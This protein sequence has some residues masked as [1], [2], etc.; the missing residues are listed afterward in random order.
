MEQRFS[1]YQARLKKAARELQ[2]VIAEKTFKDEIELVCTE[3]DQAEFRVAVIG[4]VNDG[5]T[6]FLNGMLRRPNLLPMK[7]I[8]WTA[9]VTKLQFGHPEAGSDGVAEFTYWS[10]KEMNQRI[11]DIRELI[12]N[13]EKQI[14]FRQKSESSGFYTSDDGQFSLSDAK[15]WLS[16]V[17]PR[18]NSASWKEWAGKTTVP[19][20]TLDEASL[21]PY[22]AKGGEFSLLVKAASLKLPMEPFT[23]RCSFIDTPGLNDPDRHRSQLTLDALPSMHAYI[24]VI[25]ATSGVQSTHVNILRKIR[26]LRRNRLVVVLNKIDLLNSPADVSTVVAKTRDD[27]RHRWDAEHDAC[28]VVAN[29]F[30]SGDEKWICD[31]KVRRKAEVWLRDNASDY[32]NVSEVRV[33]RPD[34][35]DVRTLRERLYQASNIPAVHA[36][37]DQVIM[38]AQGNE[39]LR[40]AKC[41]LLEISQRAEERENEKAKLDKQTLASMEEGLGKML[42]H[43]EENERKQQ[44]IRDLKNL[45]KQEITKLSEGIEAHKKMAVDQFRTAI[46]KDAAEWINKTKKNVESW[47]V[48]AKLDYD[49]GLLAE[50]VEKTINQVSLKSFR[51]IEE[52]LGDSRGRFARMLGGFANLRMFEFPIP[53]MPE[54][55]DLE[56]I[57]LTSFRDEITE[58]G[59]D[60]VSEVQEEFKNISDAHFEEIIPEFVEEF[61]ANFDNLKERTVEKWEHNIS[62]AYAFL[63]REMEKQTFQ[64]K[65]FA[66]GDS[67]EKRERKLMELK[68]H[69]REAEDASRAIAAQGRLIK[70]IQLEGN[71]E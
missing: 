31:E 15:D 38:K 3:L 52:M 10:M 32:L 13:K 46:R 70:S 63:D 60:P 57:Q 12:D 62:K 56:L 11:K 30:F 29:A 18:M 61:I 7:S 33:E 14:E 68:K 34:T 69:I 9:A 58:W 71:T 49:G 36:A 39:I 41:N 59:F 25:P 47:I 8:A 66:K 27:L 40:C 2:A 48:W 23:Q 55:G 5:K 37:V 1:K 4:T 54:I 17:E 16:Q 26:G 28:I 65:E 42:R 24:M 53:Q 6:T 45:L 22:L 20:V 51:K 43:I 21:E 19:E 67:T 35:L 50:K 44:E 64:L